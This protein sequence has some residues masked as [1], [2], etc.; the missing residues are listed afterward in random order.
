MADKLF[1]KETVAGAEKVRNTAAEIQNIFNNIDVNKLS[2]GMKKVAE[3]SKDMASELSDSLKYSKEN[4][5]IASNQSKSAVLAAKYSTTQNKLAKIFRSY[6]ISN[7]KGQDKFTEGLKES[8]QEY[9][10]LKQGAKDLVGEMGRLAGE[11]SELDNL[12]G[13]I[14]QTIGEFVSNP[15]TIATGLLLTFNSQQEAIAGQFGAMGVT[16]FGSDLKAA[17]TELSKLGFSAEESQ[18]AISDIAN[19]FG[20]SVQESAKLAQNAGEIAV[21]LGMS[22]D[23]STKLL[24]TLTTIGG[25]TSKQAT[26]LAKQTASLAEANN[27]APDEV[28]N[29]IANNTELF[30]KFAKDGGANVARAAIQ[31]RKLGVEIGDIADSMEGMLDFQGSLNAEI[32]ASVMLGRNL[33][34]QK[35]RELSLA[36]D[37]EGF[38]REILK[39]V[40]SEAEFNK[41]NV[42]QKQALAKA[43]GL[44]VDKLGKMVSR[45]KEA[46]TLAGELNKQKV[47]DLVSEKALTGMAK[48]MN[49]LKAIGIELS[50]TLGPALNTIIGAFSSMVSG[51][52]SIGG[53]LPVVITLLGAMAIKSGLAAAA[54]VY[55]SLTTLGLVKAK[56]ADTEAEVRNQGVKGRGIALS[57]RSA[58]T[59]IFEAI[60]LAGKGA[61]QIAS[62]IPI[63]GFII[64][65]ALLAGFVGYLLG[66]TNAAKSQ[67]G[68]MFSPAGGSTMISTKEGGLFEMSKNDDILAGPGLASAVGGGGGGATVVNTDTS[69]MEKQGLE[70]NTKLD[71]L[72]SVMIE[73][74]KQIG[75]KV[76]S[77]FAS[78]K[79][80]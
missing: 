14:G 31:A 48:F 7:L 37:I 69:A 28:L 11:V 65:G 66:Q 9:N 49:E 67:A 80:A 56:D 54:N 19:Q 36:G 1:G 78:A 10:N 52:N 72:I 59:K 44:S 45:E 17:N 6:Q 18:K 29:D 24:G 63:A 20:L 75:K 39:Q 43:T 34:L 71:Q 25:L 57:L 74:P 30:A 58:G 41:L 32:E 13:G 8:S 73:Q 2:T 61:A 21:G 62:M 76:S 46:A 64:G 23:E 35:A 33:N 55:Q 42:L 40:G 70:T 26:D 15:L 51:L 38:Q 68:D 4:Q 27:V 60:A 16:R 77:G 79:N 3:A 22:L 47:E 50:N 5:K 53:V 12:F